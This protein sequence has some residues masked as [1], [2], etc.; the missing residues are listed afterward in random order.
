MDFPKKSY[1]MR[2]IALCTQTLTGNL[3]K[4]LVQFIIQEK[5]IQKLFQKR[6]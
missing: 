4:H 1:L 6:M 3:V 2:W 5:N